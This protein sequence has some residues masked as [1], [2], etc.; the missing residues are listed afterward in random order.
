MDDID[1]AVSILRAAREQGH[2]MYVRACLKYIY[3]MN[4][5]EDDSNA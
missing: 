4:P 1:E 5:I 2:E 3:K